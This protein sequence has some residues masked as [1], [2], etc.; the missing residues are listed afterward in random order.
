MVTIHCVGCGQ[1]AEELRREKRETHEL[2]HC[3][4]FNAAC[5][6]APH[7]TVEVP[8]ESMSVSIH[9]ARGER[10]IARGK[11]ESYVPGGHGGRRAYFTH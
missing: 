4:C 11:K 8:A 7:F 5:A 2:V 3:V 1:P 9:L 6:K 10:L